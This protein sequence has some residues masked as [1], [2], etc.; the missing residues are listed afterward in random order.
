MRCIIVYPLPLDNIY[1]FATFAKRFIDTFKQHP[2]GYEDYKLVVAVNGGRITDRISEEFQGINTTYTE[3]QGNG[4]DIG[5]AQFVS[6]LCKMPDDFMVCMTSRCYFHREGWLKRYAEARQK[7]GPGLYGAFAS[8]ESGMAHIC[9]RGYALDAEHFRNYP[10]L[11][12][13]RHA[14]GQE[15]ETGKT[16]ISQW[17][18]ERQFPLMQVT[19]D[20]EQDQAHWRDPYQHGIYRRGSQNACLIWDRHT[21][22]FKDANEKEKK[23]LQDM[24]DGIRC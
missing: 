10:H 12:D 21:D 9:T 1:T 18:R 8:H 23:R 3:Y 16:C 11:I 2:P 13:Q 20:G 4:W 15:F 24:A 17:F 19:W 5:S 22:L 14:K 6:T 7:H